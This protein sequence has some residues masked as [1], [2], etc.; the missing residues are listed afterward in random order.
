MHLSSLTVLAFYLN[1]AVDAGKQT[2]F[3]EI[4]SQIEAG[5]IFEYLKRNVERIDLSML[6]AADRKELVEEWQRI[7]NAVDPRRKLAVE[8]NGYCL[9]LAYVIQGIQQRA[10]PKE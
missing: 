3:E 2:S 8:N 9:L 1:G 6:T 10:E 4:Y 5:T 7:A